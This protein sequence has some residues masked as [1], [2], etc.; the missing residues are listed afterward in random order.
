MKTATYN[1]VRDDLR[2][3]RDNTK[4]FNRAFFNAYIRGYKA[5]IKAIEAGTQTA[6][7]SEYREAHETPFYQKNGGAFCEFLEVISN[8]EIV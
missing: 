3:R 7:F 6:D 2:Q 5:R 1:T 4:Y 8:Y